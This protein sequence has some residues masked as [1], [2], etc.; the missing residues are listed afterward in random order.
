MVNKSQNDPCIPREIMGKKKDQH[1]MGEL[2]EDEIKKRIEN[3]GVEPTYM[4][5]RG[6]TPREA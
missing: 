5:E 2:D 3:V 1:N 6:N 4:L